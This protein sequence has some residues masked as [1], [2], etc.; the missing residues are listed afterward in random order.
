VTFLLV[1][2]AGAVGAAARFCLDGWILERVGG[3]FPWGTFVIN[4]SGSLLLGFVS[5][6]VLYHGLPETPRLLVGVGF[7]GAYTTF[8][9]FGYD[10]IRLAEGD[11][12]LPAGAYA[13]GSMVAGIFAAASGIA[14]AAAV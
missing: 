10:A 6:L 5:G 1:A 8:S 2:L 14:I 3:E 9:T 13:L 4:V 7:C 12:G 11:A